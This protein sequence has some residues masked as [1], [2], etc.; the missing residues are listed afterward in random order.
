M[1][2]LSKSLIHHTRALILLVKSYTAVYEFR[3]LPAEEP[4][5][6]STRTEPRTSEAGGPSPYRESQIATENA[7]AVEDPDSLLSI[8]VI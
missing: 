6:S 5:L 3:N 4:E 2:I 8:N 7:D 1:L